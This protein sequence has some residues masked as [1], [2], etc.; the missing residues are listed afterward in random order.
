MFAMINTLVVKTF[1]IRECGGVIAAGA[2]LASGKIE[3]PWREE[4]HS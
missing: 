1:R 2:S 4:S 3:T